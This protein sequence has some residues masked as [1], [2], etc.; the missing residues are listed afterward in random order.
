MATSVVLESYE[1][2][3]LTLDAWA[4]LDDEPGEF[5]DGRLVEE[6]VPSYLHEITVAS[7]IRLLDTWAS[8][9]GG[10]VFGSEA[11]LG[12]RELRRGRKPDV[13]MYLRGSRRPAA[14]SSMSE[15]P[16][17]VAIEV[18]SPQP[19]DAR[20]DR[21]EKLGEY[22]QFGVRFYWLIDPEERV[23]QILELN[24][25]GRYAIA[26]TASEGTHEVPGCE[27]LTLDLDA[28]WAR[29]DAWL[30]DQVEGAAKP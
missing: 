13:S 27:G 28:L 16:P 30:E 11:K 29:L 15:C 20:R 25:S 22:A 12:M 3:E 9:R 10:W 24:E 1:P 6:E 19:R 17:D 7:L 8:A 2:A 23:L 14:R 26:L 21:V 5:V 18:L 4:D